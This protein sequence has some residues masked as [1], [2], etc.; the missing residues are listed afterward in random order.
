MKSSRMACCSADSGGT[1]FGHLLADMPSSSNG[2]AVGEILAAVPWWRGGP[3]ACSFCH[4][5][6]ARGKGKRAGVWPAPGVAPVT[7]GGRGQRAMLVSG[8]LARGASPPGRDAGEAAP[9]GQGREQGEPAPQDAVGQPV[10]A[11][12]GAGRGELILE[13]VLAR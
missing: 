6:P 13:A 4:K 12:P 3:L 11:N 1:V 10:E 8:G 5:T 7:S 9:R 2:S